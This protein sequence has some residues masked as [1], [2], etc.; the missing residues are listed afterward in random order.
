MLYIH[1]LLE[2]E[3]VA[4]AFVDRPIQGV[5]MDLSKAFDSVK[6]DTYSL[7][8]CRKIKRVALRLLKLYLT[9]NRKQCV[10]ITHTIKNTKIKSV[11]FPTSCL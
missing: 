3:Q 1:Y 4:T 9:A 5:F 8:N 6:H 11:I 2:Q 10:E 7:Q